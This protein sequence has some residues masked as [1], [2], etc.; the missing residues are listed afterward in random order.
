MTGDPSERDDCTEINDVRF[1]CSPFLQE[2]A[3]GVGFLIGGHIE[4]K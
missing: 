3:L 1:P 2:R 4:K